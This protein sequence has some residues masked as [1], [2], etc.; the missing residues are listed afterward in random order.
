[1]P[2]SYERGQELRQATLPVDK[3]ICRQKKPR[4]FRGGIIECHDKPRSAESRTCDYGKALSTWH[5][6]CGLIPILVTLR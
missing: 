5:D 4:G 2:K 3:V 6:G 1:M